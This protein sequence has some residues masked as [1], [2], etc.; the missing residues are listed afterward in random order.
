MIEN[1]NQEDMN[2]N[3]NQ[4]SNQENTSSNS[5]QNCN[6]E[7][8]APNHNKNITKIDVVYFLIGMFAPIVVAILAYIF[9]KEEDIRLDRRRYN[10]KYQSRLIL[11]GLIVAL[12]IKVIYIIFATIFGFAFI[13]LGSKNL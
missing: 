6:Q 7:S 11:V 2:N 8:V 1:N 13:A 4:D 5:N 3:L 10:G 9:I 12:V